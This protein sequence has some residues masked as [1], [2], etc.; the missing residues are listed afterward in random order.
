LVVAAFIMATA[1]GEVLGMVIG[2][3]ALAAR[4]IIAG[5]SLIAA[6]RGVLHNCDMPI[7]K[8]KG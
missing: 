4:E 8:P 2:L 7:V 6:A 5:A 1:V 3:S